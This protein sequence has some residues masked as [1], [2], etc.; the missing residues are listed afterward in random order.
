MTDYNLSHTGQE[1]DNAINS[2]KNSNLDGGTFDTVALLITH[3]QGL[4]T[5]PAV[6]T[7]FK[8]NGRETLGDSPSRVFTIKNGTHV[9]NS[10]TIRTIDVSN[11]IEMVYWD[12]NVADFSTQAL[13]EAA[14]SAYTSTINKVNDLGVD[15]ITVTGTYNGYVPAAVASNPTNGNVATVDAN[16]NI[17]SSSNN[18]AD[19]VLDTASRAS[20]SLSNVTNGSVTFDLLDSELQSSIGGELSPQ[21]FLGNITTLGQALPSPSSSTNKYYFSKVAGSLTGSNNSSQTVENGGFLFSNGSTWTARGAAPTTLATNSVGKD[22]LDDDIVSDVDDA[23]RKVQDVL[24]PT[25]NLYNVNDTNGH[26][27]DQFMNWITSTGTT[28]NFAANA[29]Y[30]VTPFIEVLPNTTYYA[31]HRH[32]WAYFDAS[33]GYIAGSISTVS[34]VT[35]NQ[36]SDVTAG[37]IA[38][39]NNSS[40]KY[41]RLNISESVTDEDL[42]YLVLGSSALTT[43]EPYGGKL[44]PTAVTLDADSFTDGSIGKLK[45]DFFTKGKNLFNTSDSTIIAN[46][47]MSKTGALTSDGSRF[48]SHFIPVK[49]NQAYAISGGTARFV[50]AFDSGKT[51]VSSAGLGDGTVT[52]I[53]SYTTPASGVAFIRFT[54]SNSAQSSYQFEE[55]SSATT[56]EAYSETL[57]PTAIKDGSIATTKLSGGS[58][59]ADGSV[60]SVKIAAGNVVTASIADDAVTTDK[61]DFL[62]VAKNLFDVNDSAIVDGSFMSHSN[63]AV[64]SNATYFISHFIPVTASTAYFVKSAS[65]D[66]RFITFFNSSQAVVSGG[67]ENATSFT[68]SSS[69]AFVKFTGYASS[70]ATYQFELGSSQTGFEAFGST[71]DL[72]KVFF[73]DTTHSANWANK[74]FTSYGDSVT[75]QATFQTYPITHLSLVHTKLGVGGRR[76]SGSSGMVT[77]ANVD[78][79]GTD[80]QLL[81]VLG[82]TNDWANNVTIGSATSTNEAEFYGALNVMAERLVRRLPTCRIVFGTIPNSAMG[83]PRS[84]WTANVFQADGSTPVTTAGNSTGFALN[85]GSGS[86]TEAYSD[87]IRT[88]ADKHG[89]PVIDYAKESGINK[90]NLTNFMSDDGSLIHPNTAGGRRIGE[91]L[92]GRLRDIAP[93]N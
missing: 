82:G 34:G 35:N 57:I 5:L 7:T 84:G 28:L 33:Y 58:S 14:E 65:N 17:V 74:K 66:A 1:I 12:G 72:N 20:T 38:V 77:Q 51:N 68:T 18:L 62:T 25:S 27:L 52:S 45:T 16:G 10:G 23:F 56:F 85:H 92:T 73:R 71:F 42:F 55:G 36:P 15:N 8:T 60:T 30:R 53:T 59:L 64:T 21:N 87:A 32:S 80:C 41:I 86:T 81:H 46:N 9:N 78:T 44:S 3:L 2:V 75:S 90:F 4:T 50:T 39:P 29:A 63:G 89:F 37:T 91:V 47:F 31:P 24:V 61:A 22:A 93:T 54:G 40:I 88:V 49:A 76:I 48:V 26:I 67:V 70:K 79:I 6:G 11:Y 83:L 13:A 43:F 69:T 19:L